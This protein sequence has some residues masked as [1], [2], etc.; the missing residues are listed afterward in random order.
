MNKW[1]LTGI[2]ILLVLVAVGVAYDLGLFEG[3]TGSGMAII[4]AAV[5]APYMAVKNFLFGNKELRQFEEKYQELRAVEV[6]HR[7]SLD[8]SI[9]AKEKRVAELDREIQLLDSKLEILELKKK[10]VKREVEDMTIEETKQE[11]VDLFG[12]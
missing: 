5:A 7:S 2:I 3:I 9:R 1:V 12:D 8:V 6:Q 10:K 11:I 4:L